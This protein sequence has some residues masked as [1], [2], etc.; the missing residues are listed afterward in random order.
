MRI[1][2]FFEPKQGSKMRLT[3]RELE[4]KLSI[5]TQKYQDAEREVSLFDELFFTTYADVSLP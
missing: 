3:I 4:E 1:M 2:F 5:A